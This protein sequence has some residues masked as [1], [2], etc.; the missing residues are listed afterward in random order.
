MGGG[1]R[2]FK[3]LLPSGI[4]INNCPEILAVWE[5]LD[6]A[7]GKRRGTSQVTDSLIKRVMDSFAARRTKIGDGLIGETI[8]NSQPWPDAFFF[9][10]PPLFLNTEFQTEKKNITVTWSLKTITCIFE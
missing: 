8:Y 7:G 5:R 10:K 2:A 9:V 4:Q 1:G 3:Q 6:L